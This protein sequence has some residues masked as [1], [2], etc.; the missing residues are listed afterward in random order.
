SRVVLYNVNHGHLLRSGHRQIFVIPDGPVD[1][2]N[3]ISIWPGN[4]HIFDISDVLNWAGH[5][6]VLRAPRV[7]THI[8]RGEQAGEHPAVDR[9]GQSE[10]AGL[11][12]DLGRRPANSE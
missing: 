7:G 4:A 3:E 5:N 8:N 1:K 10:I 6:I 2:L 11:E 9:G 12:F